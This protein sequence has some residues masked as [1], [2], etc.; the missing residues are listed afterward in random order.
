MKISSQQIA[1]F[2][3]EIYEPQDMPK[4]ILWNWVYKALNL[5]GIDVMIFSILFDLTVCTSAYTSVPLTKMCE[6]VGMSRQTLSKK[7]D[8]IPY[9]D[10]CAVTNNNKGK[11]YTHNIYGI[12]AKRLYDACKAYSDQVAIEYEC[13]IKN[14]IIDHYPQ[15][16]KDID[17]IFIKMHEADYSCINVLDTYIRTN[18]KSDTDDVEITN[19]IVDVNPFT[20]VF[21]NLNPTVSNVKDNKVNVTTNV[22]SSNVEAD[23]TIN[24][25]THNTKS[26][27][28][29]VLKGP[30]LEQYING[31][32]KSKKAPLKLLNDKKS[33][34]VKKVKKQ[35]ESEQS[36]M[37]IVK[38]NENFAAMHCNNDSTI[39]EYLDIILNNKKNSKKY[40]NKYDTK[41]WQICLNRLIGCPIDVIKADLEICVIK[42]YSSFGYECEK[43]KNKQNTKKVVYSI[44]DEYA[45]THLDITPP[46]IDRLQVFFDIYVNRYDVETSSIESILNDLDKLPTEELKLESIE[47]SIQCGYKKFYVS[48]DQ[49][50]KIKDIKASEFDM[51][52][53]LKAIDD[54]IDREYLCLVPDIKT[55]LV[56]YVNS[57]VGKAMDIDTFNQELNK[58]TYYAGGENAILEAVKSAVNLQTN[59]L[60]KED[61]TKTNTIKKTY[62]T[63]ERYAQQTRRTRKGNCE[64]AYMRPTFK[65]YKL[66]TPAIIAEFDELK[67]KK[68]VLR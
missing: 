56:A 12:N 21:V 61:Y 66:L 11:C 5:R 10:K 38:L 62:S 28:P 58:L 37:D 60:C 13:D 53:K 64:R 20:N 39:A 30:Q 2:H 4:S 16:K 43:Y 35:T 25:N 18:K 67:N 45:K 65:E 31:N 7:L 51:S 46:I 14:Y 24:A 9:I 29:N 23:V 17:E 15:C 42:T 52:A 33:K 57:K 44:V 48:R 68:T 6:W 8:A 34:E 59:Y 47:N 40:A 22:S 41:A 27:R 26:R 50:A 19:D 55:S 36:Y 3:S 1:K 54:F 63:L 32:N 49:E